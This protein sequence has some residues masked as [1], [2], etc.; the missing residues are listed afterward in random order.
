LAVPNVVPAV[1]H[2]DVRVRPVG[3]VT[4]DRLVGPVSVTDE[5]LKSLLDHCVETGLRLGGKLRNLP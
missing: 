3:Q 2:E 1:I 4:L 5:D